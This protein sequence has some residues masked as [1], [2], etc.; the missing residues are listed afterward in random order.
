MWIGLDC[1][2]RSE[3]PSPPYHDISKKKKPQIQRTKMNDLSK[4]TSFS[5]LIGTWFLAYLLTSL[6]PK[7]ISIQ[8]HPAVMVDWQINSILAIGGFHCRHVD[9]QN[10]RKFLHTVGIKIEVNSHRRKSYC[11]C[12]PTWPP[13]RHM[14]TINWFILK[15]IF[16][17]ETWMFSTKKGI[18]YHISNISQKERNL[19]KRKRNDS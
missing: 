7:F 5:F 12:P 18:I 10:K 15:G 14:Q 16:V 1:L 2:M 17:L 6:V 4:I 19:L 8:N 11:S 3:A 13:W 9:G